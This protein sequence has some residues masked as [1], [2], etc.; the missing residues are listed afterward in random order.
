MHS[1]ELRETHIVEFK[2]EDYKATEGGRK[3]QA[4]DIAALAIDGGVLVIGIVEDKLTG[5][6]TDLAAVPVEGVVERIEQICAGR[7]SPALAVTIDDH[8]RDPMDPTCG[9]IVVTVPATGVPHMVDHRYVGRD[10][11]TTRYLAHEEVARLL[12]RRDA[13]ADLAGM[14]LDRFYDRMGTDGLGPARLVVTATPVPIL[15][16]Q[17]LREQLTGNWEQRFTE[18]LNA[19]AN[20]ME[21]ALTAEPQLAELTYRDWSFYHSGSGSSS[22]RVPRGVA[23]FHSGGAR[24]FKYVIEVSEAGAVHVAAADVYE[25][26][27]DQRGRARPAMFLTREALT[28]TARAIAIA[29]R[30]AEA[31]GTQG[32]YGL[33]IKV[34]GIEGC[35]AEPR[36]S[37]ELTSRFLNEPPYREDDYREVTLVTGT[38]LSGRLSPLVDH[39][40]GP[41]LRAMNYGDPLRPPTATY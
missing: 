16:P 6:A 14:A 15:R 8:I 3:E 37:T 41:L 30:V 4:K 38:E 5:L 13:D 33:G 27:N 2:G 31:A 11:R 17:I 1:K 10:N 36:N 20:D 34:T 22:R 24:E 23:R 29:A 26:V 32:S 39:L 12:A 40:L 19:A 28:V 9:L 18:L 21:L 35:V 7:I 25:P